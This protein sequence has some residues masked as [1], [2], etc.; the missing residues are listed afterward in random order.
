MDFYKEIIDLISSNKIHSKE[1]LHKIKV[2]LCKKYNMDAIPPD[3]DI[4]AQTGIP[5]PNHNKLL[6]L[7]AFSYSR[8]TPVGSEFARLV[9]TTGN[10][11]FRRDVYK[12]GTA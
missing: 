2:K 6:T 12:P 4:L 10:K 1:E 5:A 3:S 9:Y 7:V 11:H 8:R